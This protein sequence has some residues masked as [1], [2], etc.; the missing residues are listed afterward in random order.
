VVGLAPDADLELS[1]FVPEGPVI[2]VIG[3]EHKG[4][5]R[6]VR[7]ACTHLVR[8]H[9]SGLVQSLNASVAAGIA[10]HHLSTK[11]PRSP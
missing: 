9:Q 1:Q 11:L 7:R 10:L 4:M 8:L 3:S 6:A 5:G 2:L